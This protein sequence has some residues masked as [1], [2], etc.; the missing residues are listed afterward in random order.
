MFKEEGMYS[1]ETVK[2][3]LE[4]AIDSL[5]DNF[6]R[7]PYIHRC[8]HSIHCELYNMLIV[9][10]ALQGLQPLKNEGRRTALIHKEWPETKPSPGKKGRGN[11]DLAILDPG[12]IKNCELIAFTKGLIRPAF[13]VEMGLNYG[14]SHLQND[15]RKLYNSECKDGYLV[16]LWQP[17][18]GISNIDVDELSNWIEVKEPKHGVAAVLFRK[19]GAAMVKHLHDQNFANISK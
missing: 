10:R 9:H 15:N 16:H 11:F 3:I 2:K 19:G 14:L 1:H 5:V 12:K 13:V 8:E 6:A 4:T 18:K 7:E 17:H